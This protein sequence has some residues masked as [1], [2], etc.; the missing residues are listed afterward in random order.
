MNKVSISKLVIQCA[1]SKED[2]SSANENESVKSF[3]V[4][5]VNNGTRNLTS[6]YDGVFIAERN[7]LKRRTSIYDWLMHLSH[8]I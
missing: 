3:D 2:T 8:T 4:K 1:Q 7:W 6:L 5:S